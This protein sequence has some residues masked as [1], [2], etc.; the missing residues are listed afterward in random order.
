MQPISIIGRTF[1]PAMC[2][3]TEL[4][5]GIPQDALLDEVNPIGDDFSE[6]VTSDKNE[7]F[8]IYL[9]I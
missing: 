6:G 2:V 4:G 5:F 8:R 3:R 9:T 7:Q 1:S